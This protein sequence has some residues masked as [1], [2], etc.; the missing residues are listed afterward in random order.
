[1]RRP[2]ARLLA[3]TAALLLTLPA[4]AQRRPP[5]DEQ[6]GNEYDTD[7]THREADSIEVAFKTLTTI[8]LDRKG[9]LLA[10]DGAARQIRVIGPDGALAATWQPGFAPEALCVAPDG[11]VYCGGGGKLAE[12]DPDTGVPVRTVE[13][14]ADVASD[15]GRRRRRG[16]NRGNLVSGL[17][18]S[19]RDVFVTYGTGWSTGAKAKLFRLG[20]DLSQPTVLAEGLRG[21]CQRCDIVFRDGILYVAEN[22]AHRVVRYDREGKMLSKWGQ[23]SRTDPAGFGSCCNPMNLA[24]A[25]DG[26]LYTAESG[27]GRVKRYAPDGRF[28]SVVG[29]VGTTRFVRASGL[30]A[31]CSNIA[32]APTPDGKTIYVMD[33]K[34]RL[35]RVL[36]R[37]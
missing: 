21:C 33:F 20:R 17:A 30:A 8:C 4:T 1:M 35:I 3:A 26:M 16:G 28:D 12:L 9:R 27:M 32:L 13:A 31:S 7:A 10:G 15:M 11:A 5:G 23:R 34:D 25:A 36:E 18:A 19:K 2:F 29:Y 22:A 24:F 14:P 6:P 37:R